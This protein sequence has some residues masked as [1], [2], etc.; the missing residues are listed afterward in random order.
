MR[1]V[2][3]AM[4]KVLVLTIAV[5]GAAM[6]VPHVELQAEAKVGNYAMMP[7]NDYEDAHR[8]PL[9]PDT[10]IK[11]HLGKAAKR[12]GDKTTDYYRL[13]IPKNDYCAL[14]FSS[15]RDMTLAIWTKDNMPYQPTSSGVYQHTGQSV[16]PYMQCLPY[17]KGVYHIFVFGEGS[18]SVN[19]RLCF[20]TATSRTPK[21]KSV[22]KSKKGQLDLT[23]L[24]GQGYDYQIQ[25]A[26]DS[27]FTQNVTTKFINATVNPK[28]VSCYAG[29]TLNSNK[30]IIRF[31]GPKK[32]KTYYVRIRQMDGHCKYNGNRNGIK[33]YFK[34]SKAKKVAL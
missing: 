3:K 9:T 27:D 13:V 25:W 18:D 33:I 10:V 21:L 24:D 22:K 34:W 4:G 2:W 8:L 20:K 16:T 32:G 26:T 19:Y 31:K 7:P 30:T 1:N 28:N 6:E 15:D 23:F 17:K 5:T 12:E 11:A 14:D 29:K